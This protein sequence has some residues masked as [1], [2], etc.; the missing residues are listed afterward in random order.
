V[1]LIHVE[2]HGRVQGVGFRWFVREHA[3]RLDLAGWVRN[4][5]DG[6]VE[7]VASGEQLAVS[8]LRSQLVTGPDAAVVSHL[9]E[10]PIDDDDQLPYPFAVLR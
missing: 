10:L 1:P 8:T 5:P 7:V 6:S 2:V 4:R 3:R 9:V